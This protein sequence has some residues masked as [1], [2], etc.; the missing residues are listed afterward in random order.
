MKWIGLLLIVVAGLLIAG[1]YTVRTEMTE[2]E[3]MRHELAALRLDLE[4][5]LVRIR[6]L[7]PRLERHLVEVAQA[8]ASLDSAFVELTL[9]RR[10]LARTRGQLTAL[11][12][13]SPEPHPRME[14]ALVDIEKIRGD[15]ERLKGELEAVRSQVPR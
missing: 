1:I 5:G 14:R 10:V 8:R 7:Q 6:A 2:L 9:D 11:S 13:L 4:S 12:E 15:L 3:R